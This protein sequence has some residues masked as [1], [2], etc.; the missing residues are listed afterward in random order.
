LLLRVDFVTINT[1]TKVSLESFLP[2]RLV[3]AGVIFSRALRTVYGPD[4]DLSVSEWR[5]FA[6]LGEF[7]EMGAKA[8]GAHSSMH[9][10]KV[11]RAVRVLEDRR[12]LR[13]RDSVEDR[14]EELLSLTLLGRKAYERL[15]PRVLEF[16][17]RMK[18]TLG[19]DAD[20]FLRALARLERFTP[21]RQ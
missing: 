1:M 10:T 11:S 19:D 4:Y 20:A 6:T 21:T 12:C 18:E 7:E 5:V 13:R 17:Q 16:E 8:I 14:R 2:Y 9:K 15:V 3:R